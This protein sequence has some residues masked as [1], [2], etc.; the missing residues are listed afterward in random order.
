MVWCLKSAMVWCLNPQKGS[1]MGC[2]KLNIK[3]SLMTISGFYKIR[4]RHRRFLV[5]SLFFKKKKKKFFPPP[6]QYSDS[7]NIPI[8]TQL[9]CSPQTDQTVSCSCYTPPIS[10]WAEHVSVFILSCVARSSFWGKISIF[11][12]YLDLVYKIQVF[13]Y[14][15]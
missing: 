4:I 7:W 2:N 6:P 1:F 15:V 9:M 12:N 13:L 14:L 8:Q 11:T 3:P 5:R 10:I